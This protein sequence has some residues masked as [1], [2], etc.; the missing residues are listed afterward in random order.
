MLFPY[1]RVAIFL[2]M[3]SILI[4]NESIAQNSMTLVVDEVQKYFRAGEKPIKNI[5][6]TNLDDRRAFY[7]KTTIKKKV[8]DESLGEWKDDDTKDILISPKNFI[9]EPKKTRIIRAVKQT[10]M[11]DK[12]H[13]YTI[14][15]EP[16]EYKEDAPWQNMN[17]EG[18]KMATTFVITSGLLMTVSPQNPNT[19]ITWERDYEGITF[20]NDGNTQVDLRRRVSYCYDGSNCMEL[21]GQRIHPGKEWR[22]KVDGS[23]PIEWSYAVYNRVSSKTLDIEALD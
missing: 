3:I 1:K 6:L 5:R 10:P 13:M 18:V 23:I 7:V 20:R 21:P 4:S 12:E 19:S 22:F 8:F 9:L 2:A 15:F 14:S 11:D 17:A 16:R